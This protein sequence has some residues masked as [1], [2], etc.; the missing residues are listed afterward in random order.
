VK[1]PNCNG[2]DPHNL[3]TRL[4]SKARETLLTPRQIDSLRASN[5]HVLQN[6]GL[7]LGELRARL[8]AEDEGQWIQR[9]E[10]IRSN[11]C[12]STEQVLAPDYGAGD[13]AQKISNEAMQAGRATSEIV[14]QACQQFSKPPLWAFLLFKLVRQFKCESCVE[15]GTCVGIS[16]AY[17]AAALELNGKGQLV[18][19]EGAPA[20]GAI[21]VRTLSSLGL[22]HRAQVKIGRFQ[23]NLSA[24]LTDLRTID[25]AFIDGH[26]EERATIAYFEQIAHHAAQPA[27]VVIDDI[28]WSDGMRRAWL[29]IWANPKIDVALDLDK[30]GVC[31]LHADVKARHRIVIR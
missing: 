18:T 11:L 2:R 24:I 6:A 27:I 20:F 26:H 14:G 4:Q 13:P 1:P 29:R 31:V 8:M 7:V 21:A 28:T 10:R 15:L 12:A 23:D 25:Y 9:I 22:G 3:F 5:H 30:V 19:L 16:A 17:Q